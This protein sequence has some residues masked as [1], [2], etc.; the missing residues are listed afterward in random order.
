MNHPETTC[1]EGE[2]GPAIEKA[3]NPIDPRPF[4]STPTI[5]PLPATESTGHRKG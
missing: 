5:Q 4:P 1:Q 3:L 2:P